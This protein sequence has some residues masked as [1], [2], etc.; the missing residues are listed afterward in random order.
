MNVDSSELPLTAA[1]KYPSRVELLAV[2]SEE[3]DR[4]WRKR[5]LRATTGLARSTI[6]EHLQA[7]REL[8][9]VDAR[10]AAGGG[11]VYRLSDSEQA[12]SVERLAEALAKE[13]LE[14]AQLKEE[15]LTFLE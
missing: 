10:T 6:N 5:D 3:P 7:L 4:E 11:T 13:M 15:V 2:L 1:L 9:F 14:E 12:R 8:E